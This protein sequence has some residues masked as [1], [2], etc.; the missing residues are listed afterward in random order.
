MKG[1]P[2]RSSRRKLFAIL[3]L[4]AAALSTDCRKA[5][6]PAGPSP[7]EPAAVFPE[8]VRYDLEIDTDYEQGTLAG[9]CLLTI[10]NATDAPIAVVPL[11]LYR[12]MAV[13]SVTD[14]AGKALEF[15]QNVRI[16]EDWKE[17]QV[18]HIRVALEPSLAPGKETALRIKYAGPLL[19]YAEAMRYVKDRVGRDLTLVRSDSFAFPEIGVPSWKTNRAAGLKDFDYR[20]SLTVPSPFVVANAGNLVSRTEKDGRTTFV[21]ESRV[22]SWRIDLAAAEYATLESEDGRFRIF[23]FPEDTDGAR[24]LL[25]S[26]EATLALF[27]RWFGPLPVFRGL[28]VIEI[29]AGYGSQADVA[30]VIQEAAAFKD[31]AGR[32]TFYHELSHLW[33]VTANDP[34][35]P[36]FESEG[37]AMF[38]Q[39]LVQEKLEGKAGAVDR[40]ATAMLERLAKNFGEHPDWTKTAMIDY[41]KKDLTDLSYRV[42]Q[43][44]FYLLHKTLGEEAFIETIAGFYRDHRAAGAT[45]AQFVEY[46]K[47]RGGPAL[48]PI[49]EDW[50]FT[51]KA[52][53]LITA[54]IT[55]EDLRRRYR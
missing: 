17:L 1:G 6:Q 10:R 12:L 36:R 38:L 4:A 14:A 21:Y 28:T 20:V 44:F 23:A 52:A 47:S 19:G 51:T 53:E 26:L 30:A 37:L 25:K 5:S 7:A 49:F 55:L 2:M 50:V 54:G 31:S 40:A 33:N 13:A 43:I 42:G 27:S 45:A 39:H 34:L 9:D 15:T 18:N 16:F 29:P 41:G 48:G 11:N 24:E 35:P 3:L 46:F 8:P 22:P 32:Y